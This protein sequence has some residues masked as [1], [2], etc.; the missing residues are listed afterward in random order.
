M[1]AALYQFLMQQE[2]NIY[3]VAKITLLSQSFFFCIAIWRL[4][5]KSAKPFMPL[6][7]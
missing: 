3:Y 1:W 5:Q 6:R 7:L 2:L 4:L